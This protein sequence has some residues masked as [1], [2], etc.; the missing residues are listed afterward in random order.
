MIINIQYHTNNHSIYGNRYHSIVFIIF[1]YFKFLINQI[2]Y[3]PLFIC[4]NLYLLKNLF[5]IF[6]F[7]SNPGK[8]IWYFNGGGLSLIWHI[9]TT[10]N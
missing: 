9:L 3:K 1:F 2:T 4:H 7:L 5:T 6:N 10:F 8:K